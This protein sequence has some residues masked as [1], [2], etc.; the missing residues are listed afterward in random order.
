MCEVL[1]VTLISYVLLGVKLDLNK[2][3]LSYYI[4]GEPHGPVAFDDL[5]GTFFPAVSVNRNVQVTLRSGIIAPESDVD[6]D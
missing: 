3:T 6:S 4:N 5:Q 2:K 1:I